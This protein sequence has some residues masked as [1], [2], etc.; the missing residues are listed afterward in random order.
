ML[1]HLCAEDAT[2]RAVGPLPQI[3]EQIGLLRIEALLT[4][5]R[6]GFFAQIDA[7]RFDAGVAHHL[8]KFAAAAADVEHRAAALKSR[9][10]ELEILLDVIFRAAKAFG[11][12]AVVER[13]LRRRLRRPC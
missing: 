7:A 4:A 10:I 12:S 13:H 6:Y 11:K 8:Q 5:A 2:E 9:Q 3:R 1:D